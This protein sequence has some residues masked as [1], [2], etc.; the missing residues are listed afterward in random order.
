MQALLSVLSLFLFAL[1]SPA[2]QKLSLVTTKNGSAYLVSKT[3][4]AGPERHK[5]AT[6]NDYS[7]GSLKSLEKH[8]HGQFEGSLNEVFHPSTPWLGG[9]ASGKVMRTTEKSMIL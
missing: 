4:K 6:S 3:S 2:D 7:G 1:P 8:C 9:L 5:H